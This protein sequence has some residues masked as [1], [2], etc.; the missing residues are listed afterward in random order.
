[1]I[2][3]IIRQKSPNKS[4]VWL[5]I[6]EQSYDLYNLCG[7]YGQELNGVF[8]YSV[9]YPSFISYSTIIGEVIKLFLSGS[10]KSMDH[11]NIRIPIQFIYRVIC[12]LESLNNFSN[13]E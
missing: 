11:T 4:A 2:K 7:N 3:Y 10:D 6:T 13:L 9:Q 12:A 1:M 8:I 5:Q